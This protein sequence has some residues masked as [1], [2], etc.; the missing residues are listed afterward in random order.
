MSTPTDHLPGPG[1]RRRPRPRRLYTVVFAAVAITA[2]TAV[3]AM[4]ASALFLDVDAGDTHEDG[5][6]WLTQTGVTSGCTANSYCPDS[7]VT[8]AQMATFLWR[9]SGDADGVDPMVDAARLEGLTLA[10]VIAAAGGGDDGGTGTAPIDDGD[11]D[12]A[13]LEGLTLAEVL[14]AAQEAVEENMAPPLWAVVEADDTSTDLVRGSGA[15]AASGGVGTEGRFTVTFDRDVSACSYQATAEVANTPVKGDANIAEVR[16][17]P[18]DNA[19][20]VWV[21]NTEK[22]DGW[23][24]DNFHLHVI[25]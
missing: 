14:T 19:V 23:I 24:N 21:T 1:P 17:G 5:I 25:C 9:L 11:V 10:E 12:A 2:L 20:D 16:P 7:P 15:T 13:S 6:S 4:A 22:Q 8:R 18:T 3:G